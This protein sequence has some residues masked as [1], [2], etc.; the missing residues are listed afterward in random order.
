[1]RDIIDKRDEQERISRSIVKFWNVNYIPAHAAEDA[2]AYDDGQ[3]L[4]REDASENLTE[5]SSQRGNGKDAAEGA[6][7]GD[8]VDQG[9]IDRILKEKD[10]E[11]QSLIRETVEEQEKE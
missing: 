4:A 6:L 2:G 10:E 11:L 9:R 5:H 3:E 1:M 7:T 8:T